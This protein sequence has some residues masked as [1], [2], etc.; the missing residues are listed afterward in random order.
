MAKAAQVLAG[1]RRDGWVEIRRTGS[2][3]TLQK[4]ERTGVFAFHDRADLGQV[5]MKQVA[6][7]FGYTIEQLR[8]L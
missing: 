8:K 2:H 7:E 4:G 6:T 3:R 5:Q 1:L